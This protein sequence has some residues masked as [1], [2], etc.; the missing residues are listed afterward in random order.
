MKKQVRK[1][2][3]LSIKKFLNLIKKQEEKL[4]ICY[5]VRSKKLPK[6]G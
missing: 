3:T 5:F 6:P 1:L 4:I 2:K